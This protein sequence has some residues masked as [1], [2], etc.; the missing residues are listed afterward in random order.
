[1]TGNEYRTVQLTSV[2]R[3]G[4]FEWHLDL[5]VLLGERHPF[6]SGTENNKT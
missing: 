2:I 3:S 1:M 4:G 6:W 5:L